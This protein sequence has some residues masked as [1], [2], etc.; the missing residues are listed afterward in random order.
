MEDRVNIGRFVPLRDRGLHALLGG[1]TFYLIVITGWPLG[2]LLAEVFFSIKDNPSFIKEVLTAPASARAFRNTA[3]AAFWASALSVLVGTLGALL[4]TLTDIRLKR[5]LSFLILL[6]MLI[7]SQITALAWK[8]MVDFISKPGSP[9]PLYSREGVILV[10]GIEHSTLVFLSVRASLQGLPWD[11]VEAAR[12]LGAR[13]L[14][15]IRTVILPLIAPG[16]LAGFAL[17]FVAGI[18]NFGV[19]ALLGIPGR[20]PVLTTLIYRKLNGFGPSV[21]GETAILSLALMGLAGLGLSLRAFASRRVSVAVIKTQSIR[22]LFPLGVHRLPVEGGMFLLFLSISLLPLIALA[23]TSFVPAVGVLLTPDTFTLGNYRAGLS[24]DAVVRAFSVSLKLSTIT[25]LVCV[26]VSIPLAYC[27]VIR[28]VPLSH[29]LVLLADAPYAIPGIVVSI[30]MILAFLKPLPLV[31]S[32]YGTAGIL[33]IAYASRFLSL[34]L[35]PTLA[36]AEQFDRHLEEAASMAGARTFRRLRTVVFPSVLPSAFSGG[37]LVFMAA[38]NEITVSSLLW[39]AGNETIG[40]MIYAMH[41]EGNSPQAAAISMI[42]VL[43]VVAI[44]LTISKLG[45]SLPEGVIPWRG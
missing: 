9:N 24:Q 31:G 43:I 23:A 39:S 27:A 6:P 36:G 16:I 14:R 28:K 15:I 20:F 4:V 17:S 1:L 41:Y 18:G 25:A 45:K 33:F 26:G 32:L 21:L 7:P 44:A 3:E 29:S 34:A 8:M 40:V 42:S 2:R 35:M 13:P 38:L 12:V 37:L 30:S 11:L 19:P 22:S 10:L 5:L